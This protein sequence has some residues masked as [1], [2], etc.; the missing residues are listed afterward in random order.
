MW[1]APLAGRQDRRQ[2]EAP[3]HDAS[4]APAGMDIT[5]VHARQ[6]A[7]QPDRQTDRQT[8]KQ[9]DREAGRHADRQTNKTT[10]AGSS[11]GR[12]Q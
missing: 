2:I 12:A 6:T 11:A 5:I 9:T 10:D 8:D 4:A 7:S 3:R 1:S